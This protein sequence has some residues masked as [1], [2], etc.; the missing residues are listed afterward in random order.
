MKWIELRNIDQ[1]D[2]LV[3][4]SG[5]KPALIFKHS[6]SCSISR[7]ALSRLERHWSDEDLHLVTPY[8]L[9]LLANRNISNSIADTF[10]VEHESPQVLIIKNGKSVYNDSHLGIDYSSIKAKL[11]E[12]VALKN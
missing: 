1:L 7:A 6:T 2:K 9:D 11:Q 4:E 8:Y 10:D 3:E 12:T 5:E